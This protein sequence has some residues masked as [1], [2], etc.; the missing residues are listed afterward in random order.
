MSTDVRPAGIAK[1]CK[2]SVRNAAKLP[3]NACA[4]LMFAFTGFNVFTLCFEVFFRA[5][6]TMLELRCAGWN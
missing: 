4:A 5:A 1:A 2:F 3:A 6:N